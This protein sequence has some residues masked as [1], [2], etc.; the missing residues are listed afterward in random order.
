[1]A[2]KIQ[3][4]LLLLEDFNAPSILSL[5][6]RIPLVHILARASRA[7]C[8]SSIAIPSALRP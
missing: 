8:G 2:Y 4:A 1:M 3:T 5:A 6:L 7:A